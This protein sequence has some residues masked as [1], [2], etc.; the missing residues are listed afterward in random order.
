MDSWIRK[1]LMIF[2]LW[3][4]MFL[5]KHV[6]D[7]LEGGDNGIFL[8]VWRWA[9]NDCIRVL[10]ICYKYVFVA[11]IW[12]IQEFSSQIMYIVIFSVSKTAAQQNSML[13]VSGLPPSDSMCTCNDF[14]LVIGL[15]VD[16]QFC[17]SCL[18]LGMS[19]YSCCWYKKVSLDGSGCKPW[20][21][22]ELM[23]V[24]GCIQYVGEKIGTDGRTWL[25]L[26]EFTCVWCSS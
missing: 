8:S 17:V 14:P 6:A 20:P 3:F 11:F 12:A 18:V 10:G 19:L 25:N 23:I 9:N 1:F 2:E 7:G 24:I 22:N 4:A 26:S 13:D 15:V 5:L 21:S 16:S